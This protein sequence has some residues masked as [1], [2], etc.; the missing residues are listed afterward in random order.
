MS[1]ITVAEN[2]QETGGAVTGLGVSILFFT[3]LKIYMFGVGFWSAL[4]V[5]VSLFVIYA[6]FTYKG[7]R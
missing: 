3:G 2:I 1:K 4:L 6:G 7:N 5:I